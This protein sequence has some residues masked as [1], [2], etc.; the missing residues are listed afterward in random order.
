MLRANSFLIGLVGAL[1]LV[2]VVVWISGGMTERSGAPNPVPVAGER[3]PDEDTLS[4]SAAARTGAP[5]TGP[6][7]RLPL[8]E[9]TAAFTSAHRNTVE[10]TRVGTAR[11]TECHRSEAE[12]FGAT[13]HA[14]SLARVQIQDE[15]PDGQFLH[16]ASAATYRIKRR[17]DQLWHQELFLDGRSNR[18]AAIE[19]ALAWRIGSGHHSRSYLIEVDGYFFESPVTWYASKNAWAMSPGFDNPQQE[20]FARAAHDGCVQ[21]HCG[22]V[23]S[24]GDSDHRL[25]I[26]EPSIGCENCHGPGSLHVRERSAGA[27]VT[28]DFDD[29]IVNPR[30]LSRSLNESV[31]A[32]CHLRAAGWAIVRGRG[33]SEFRPGL[34]LSD[35]R[36]DFVQKQGSEAMEVVGHFEQMHASRCYSQTE[37]LTC[38]TCHNPHHAPDPQDKVSHYRNICLS[39]HDDASS[40]CGLPEPQR[41]LQSETDNCVTCHMPASET[42]I[43]HF[44]F[45]HHRIGIDHERQAPGSRS[46]DLIPFGDVSRLTP[47]DLQRCLGLALERALRQF[48]PAAREVAYE[49]ALRNLTQVYRQGM[50]DAQVQGGLAYLY[51][52]RGDPKSLEF[53]R[54][55]LRSPDCSAETR[56]HSLIVLG[57][58][59]LRRGEFG[60]A[61][62]AFEQLTKVRLRFTDWQMLGVC[63]SLQNR[64]SDALT[65]FRKALKLQPGSID[66]NALLADELRKAG[67]SELSARHQDIVARLREAR[68]RAG[69]GR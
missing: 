52:M 64:S 20:G 61:A 32:R 62:D 42:D 34:P 2:V 44:T 16:A 24:A 10:A 48:E 56:I 54:E 15:P 68:Q 5:L 47:L 7:N 17:D 8:P 33:L 21:C 35:F 31:C 23:E 38:T 18:I 40:D 59:N 50:R 25:R 66:I 41:L 37:S 49:L 26:M 39:C 28:A 36:V 57:D 55:A 19:H 65:A 58:M 53:A 4:D 14:H 51:W 9:P 3:L 46:A 11:C 13:A 67:Q 45:T 22:R 29:T 12:T 63:R 6:A 27:A 43:P 1:V 60:M 30:K 69:E